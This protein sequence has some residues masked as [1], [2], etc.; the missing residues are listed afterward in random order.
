M[1]MAAAVSASPTAIA[2]E[3][4]I[5]SADPTGPVVHDLGERAELVNGS[6]VQGWTVSDLK[7]SADVIPYQVQGTL[8]E[9][10]ATDEALN[11]NAIPIVSNLN[12]RASSGETYRALFQVATPQSVRPAVLSQ[13]EKTSGK[14]YFDVTGDVPDGVTYNDGQSDLLV[15]TRPQPS[16]R[17]AV[18]L[19]QPLANHSAPASPSV[20]PTPAA[21]SPSV[22]PT[23]APAS[24]SA[25]LGSAAVPAAGTQGTSVP[26]NPASAPVPQDVPAAQRGTAG[27]SGTPVQGAAGV[28]SSGEPVPPSWQ[29]TSVVGSSGVPVPP[30]QGAAAVDGSAASAPPVQ[31][32]WQGAAAAAQ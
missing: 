16:V 21:A 13:G 1:V 18:Q 32:S 2:L 5:A 11:D 4:P 25:G 30:V 14:V 20:T 19:P 26:S 27:R 23:P 31:P 28:D 12:A 10:T 29:G 17:P 6:V 3:T 24:P 7:E 8:W 9:A 22:T 15:W